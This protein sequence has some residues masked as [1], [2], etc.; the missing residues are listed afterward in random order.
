MTPVVRRVTWADACEVL[1]EIRFKVF[2]EEQAVPI[3]EE[4]DGMDEVSTHF[5]AS[6]DGNPVGVARL[7]P[8]GQIGRMAV[9][10]PY[11]RNGI[12][13]LLLCAAVNEALENGHVEPFLHA[14][15]HALSFYEENGFSAFGE[16]FL[17]AGIEHRAMRYVGSK[18]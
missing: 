17:D 14:Q 10:I 9:L 3:E 15:T 7:M 2:V 11:R 12:G 6:L 1:K 4:L 13:A 16:L 5:I 8:S 18:K